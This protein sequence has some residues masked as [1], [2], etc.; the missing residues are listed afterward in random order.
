MAKPDSPTPVTLKP[1]DAKLKTLND[2]MLLTV[3]SVLN[4]DDREAAADKL[5]KSARS[6]CKTAAIAIPEEVD[7]RTV[8]FRMMHHG[9]APSKASR[10]VVRM[11]AR[12]C[13]PFAWHYTGWYRDGGR[14]THV[15]ENECGDMWHCGGHAD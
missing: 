12:R 7:A 10:T 14:V 8:K 1:R 2:F 9:P 11:K 6:Y 4:A 15:Y 5:N 13:N 3:A